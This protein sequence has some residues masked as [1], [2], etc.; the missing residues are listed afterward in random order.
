MSKSTYFYTKT[1]LEKGVDKY[2]EIKELIKVIYENSNGCYGHVRIKQVLNNMGISISKKKVLSITR[3]LGLLCTKYTRKGRRYNSYKGRV[4]LIADNVLNREFKSTKPNEKWSTDVTQFKV[5]SGVKVYLSILLDHFNREVVG[6]SIST[7]PTVKFTNR[8]L[9]VALRGRKISGGLYIH[10]DQGF[11]YQHDTWHDIL[12][13]HNVGAS[14][15]RKGNCLD[16]ALVENFF[17]V[18]KQE[19]Y[20]GQVYA[21]D[22][23]LSE[24]I[25]KYIYWYNNERIIMK[26]G[27]LS[28]VAYLRRFHEQYI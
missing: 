18:M 17:S 11:H 24:A 20:Y 2:K 19:M 10:S 25:D 13:E 26:L 6:Y 23:E 7:S 4:G 27:G 5:K 21:T 14:M 28:P 15:S 8:S 22:K 16:N 12:R 3:E 1:V 9:K